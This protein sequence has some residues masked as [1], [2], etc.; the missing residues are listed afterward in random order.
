MTTLASEVRSARIWL[1]HDEKEKEKRFSA[2]TMERTYSGYASGSDKKRKRMSDD[3]TLLTR[4]RATQPA[5]RPAT[6]NPSISQA[7]QGT[8]TVFTTDDHPVSPKTVKPRRVNSAT[9]SEDH[10]GVTDSPHLATP[11]AELTLGD[12]DMSG[13]ATPLSTAPPGHHA[14][15]PSYDDT[16]DHD[17]HHHVNIISVDADAEATDDVSVMP[18]PLTGLKVVIIHVKDKMNDGPK[19]GDIIL[20]EL[21][22]YEETTRLGCE[23]IVSHVG[24]SLYL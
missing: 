19:V 16:P 11:T 10:M 1:E 22:A 3:N 6:S 7:V 5:A 20:E 14:S 24:Q 9:L 13:P 4:R 18:P 23:Y 21:L 8:S 17:R 15:Q 12:I 2:P